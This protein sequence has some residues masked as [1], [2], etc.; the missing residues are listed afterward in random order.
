MLSFHLGKLG[1]DEMYF[2]ET[3]IASLKDVE[4]RNSRFQ[5]KA[6]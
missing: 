3:T 4:Y 2:L 5:C 1:C 6:L